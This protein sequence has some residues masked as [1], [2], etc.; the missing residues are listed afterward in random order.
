MIILHT[1]TPE[2]T[3]SPGSIMSTENTK[4]N[5]LKTITLNLSEHSILKNPI[6]IMK[7]E[8]PPKRKHLHIEIM[9]TVSRNYNYFKQNSQAVV[10]E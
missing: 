5:Q 10:A 3:L 7:L 2:G 9:Y 4:P 1:F 6:E 8:I